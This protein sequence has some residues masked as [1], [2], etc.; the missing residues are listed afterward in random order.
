MISKHIKTKA[1]ILP[2]KIPFYHLGSQAIQSSSEE[3]FQL[4]SGGSVS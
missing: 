4:V 2:G 3:S 1:K